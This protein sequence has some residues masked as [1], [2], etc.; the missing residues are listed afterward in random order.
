MTRFDIEAPSAYITVTFNLF[1]L[2]IRMDWNKNKIGSNKRKK[3]NSTYEFKKTFLPKKYHTIFFL[4]ENWRWIIIFC[5]F[6]FYRQIHDLC[7][8]YV[9]AVLQYIYLCIVSWTPFIWFIIDSLFLIHLECFRKI[10][11][12]LIIFIKMLD[13]MMDSFIE[14][15]LF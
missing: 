9:C 13:F 5:Y 4:K 6:V 12:I 2:Q 1:L 14:I 10:E 7:N 3:Q 15:E 11:L 8:G